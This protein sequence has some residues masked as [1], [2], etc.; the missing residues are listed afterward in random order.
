[1]KLTL[2]TIVMLAVFIRASAQGQNTRVFYYVIKA[3]KLNRNYTL[4]YYVGSTRMMGRQRTL[5]DTLVVRQGYVFSKLN[6]TSPSSYIDELGMTSRKLKCEIAKGNNC[7]IVDFWG[8]SG[9]PPIFYS[10][11]NI[12]HRTPVSDTQYFM[13]SFTPKTNLGVINKYIKVGFRSWNLSAGISALRY[14][15]KQDSA[16]ASTSSLSLIS[17]NYGRTWGF[18]KISTKRTTSYSITASV[19]SGLSAAELSEKSAKRPAWWKKS[20]SVSRTNPAI[21]YGISAILSRNNFGLVFSLGWDCN[22]GPN[23]KEWAYQNKP[24]LG[25][26]IN[27]SLGFL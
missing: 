5:T 11:A 16:S 4:S 20:E 13:F 22:F 26:G 14:R 7:L 21:S 19:F 25:L 6:R 10:T 12:T 3:K 1:M 9:N 27:A 24:W 17:F 23:S 18:S 8:F 2:F 15:P